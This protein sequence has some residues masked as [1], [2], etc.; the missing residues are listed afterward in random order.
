MT[1]DIKPRKNKIKEFC[2]IFIEDFDLGNGD[3]A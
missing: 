2:L 1:L 3:T